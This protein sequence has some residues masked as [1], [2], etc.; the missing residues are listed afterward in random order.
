M[1]Y[2]ISTHREMNIAHRY[3]MLYSFLI[4][5]NALVISISTNEYSISHRY[6]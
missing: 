5:T 3:L 1:L 4:G 2:S 6:L